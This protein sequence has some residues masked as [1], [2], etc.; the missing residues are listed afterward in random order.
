M[1]TA[2][3]VD[4]LKSG[5]KGVMQISEIANGMLDPILARR[6]GLNTMLLG[7]WDE[8]AGPEFAECTRPERIKW[9]RSA[10]Q[11]GADEGGFRPGTLT[12][13]CEGARALFLMHAQDE[14]I[15]RIN[16]FFGFAAVERVRV[17]QKPVSQAPRKRALRP[18]L[19]AEKE[20][21]AALLTEIE[22]PHLKSAL[23]RLGQA[24]AA[25]RGRR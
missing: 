19:P 2:K 21:I 24:V 25:S 7:S 5:R 22:D 23:E 10:A 4:E 9:E 8:I 20:R 14:L 3:G 18:L 1:P 15:Q 17:V 13:A 6:A 11:S 16:A 12:V